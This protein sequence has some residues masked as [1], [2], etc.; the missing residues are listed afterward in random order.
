MLINV[1][2]HNLQSIMILNLHD[3]SQELFSLSSENIQILCVLFNI[4][5]AADSKIDS[6][7]NG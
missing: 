1:K 7:L 4:V 3:W 2:V 5:S 6:W